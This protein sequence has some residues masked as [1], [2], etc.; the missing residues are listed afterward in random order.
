MST[1]TFTW[2]PLAGAQGDVI[3]RTLS[4]RFGDGYQQDAADG[5]NNKVQS[6]PLRFVGDADFIEAIQ[7]FL[8]RHAG[9]KSFYWTPPLGVQ[10]RYKV[11]QYSPAAQ[12]GLVYAL[13]AT[14][15]QAFAP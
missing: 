13:T 12:A 4:A 15:E 2:R 5:I 10:G 11:K 3:L 8:D 9:A 7:D 6:W 14:F 1:E